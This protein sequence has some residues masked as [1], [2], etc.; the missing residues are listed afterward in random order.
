MA[1]LDQ[2]G[3]A[4]EVAQLGAV[5]GREFSHEL[6]RAVSPMAEEALQQGLQQLVDAEL[7]YRRGLPSRGSYLFKHDSSLLFAA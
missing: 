6:L 4:K 1:R 3:T 2:L 7:I 5:V